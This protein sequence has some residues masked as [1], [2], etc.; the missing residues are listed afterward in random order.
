MVEFEQNSQL[1]II[2]V[3]A[4]SD[5]SDKL[6][7][8]EIPSSVEIIECDAFQNCYKLKYVSFSQDSY[9]KEIGKSALCSCSIKVTKFVNFIYYL[10][11]IEFDENTELTKINLSYFDEVVIVMVP[12]KCKFKLKV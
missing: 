7:E 9:L 8:V 1:T 11:I 6:I 3:G 10:Q 2:G 4:F 12:L 5:N